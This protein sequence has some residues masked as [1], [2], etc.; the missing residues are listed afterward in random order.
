MAVYWFTTN[1]HVPHSEPT[2]ADEKK[3]SDA[4]KPV[5]TDRY[6]D[7][8]PRGAVMRLGTLRYCQP[9]PAGLAFSPDGKM[10]ASGGV[11]NRIRF[12]DPDTG[13]ELRTLEGHKNQVNCIAFSG[14]GK[15]LAS[16]SQDHELMLW[17][18]DA[19]KLQR[20]FD[21]HDAPIELL[22]LSPDGKVLASSCLAGTLRLWDTQ[23]GKEI[24]SLP[25]DAGLRVD[26]MLFTP[27]SRHLLF[28]NDTAEGIQLVDVAEGKLLRTF[29]GHRDSHVHGL[30]IS[31]DGTTLISGGFDH[32]IRAW[33]VASGKERQRYGDEK[34]A[35]RC[36]AL[37]PDGK[38]LTYGTYPDGMVHIW[39]IAANK[40]LVAPWKAN[41]WCVASIAYSPDSKKVA[42]GR[43]TIAIHE[44]ATGKRLNPPAESEARVHQVE[45]AP[46]GKL[47]AVCRDDE[48][49][50]LWETAKWRPA[51][52]LKAEIGHFTSMA[53][54]PNGKYLTTAES[55][56]KQAV[57][58]HWD[59]QT[60]KRLREFPR[61]KG[62]LGVLS[63]SADG[64]TLACRRPPKF[65]V[66]WDAAACNE[67]SQIAV[68]DFD[69]RNPRLSPDGRLLACKTSKNAVA[70]W[71]T[72][73][74]KPVRSFG[75][76]L[77][78]TEGLIA[79]SPD[80]KTIATAAG[81]GVDR[82]R[83]I[84]PDIV[85]WDTATGDERLQIAMPEGKLSQIAFS[86]DGRLLAS[87][88]ETEAI[89]LWDTRTGKEVGRFTGHRGRIRTLSFAPD[90]KTLASGGFDSTVLIWDVFGVF[91]H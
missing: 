62:W 15:W 40:D 59:P 72:K 83:P 42:L 35:V 61:E 50:E 9:F 29:K 80:G 6:G 18:V 32:T 65:F 5:S 49:I 74:Q 89:L 7:P 41:P 30:A 90:G 12:W 34:S 56:N 4:K 66:L 71:D 78:P 67:R 37:A 24:R 13:K 47:L 84:Q 91:Q 25:I 14:D 87:V 85:L 26:A 82:R 77:N 27:D 68:E 70:L 21:G 48:G 38:T 33:D 28:N 45:Y 20:R 75:K 17:D 63:Y 60:G 88:G 73:T 39:D 2:A 11:D 55:D 31:V 79:F 58:C 81:Q 54:S 86:P 1:P 10:L 19:G 57:I 69:A 43:D 22:A 51:A 53:F 76:T 23:A 64:E 52:T 44:T 36:L 8:L 3:D 16:G 46:N